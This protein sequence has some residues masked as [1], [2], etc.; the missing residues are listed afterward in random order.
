MDYQ[1]NPNKPK[2]PKPDKQI[3]KV[4]T[5]EV[6]QKPKGIGRKFR[7]VFLGGDLKNAARY[8]TGDVI[9][10]AFR[11]LLV[12]AITNGAKRFVYGESMY[13][14]RQTEYRPRVSYN[15]P[16][17]RGM[18]RDPRDRA[19]LPDQPHSYR[20]QRQERDDIILARRED[21]ELVVERLIDI[22]NQYDV[23]SLADLYDLLGQQ[24]SHV[25]NKW[26][27]TYLNNVEIR[28][29]RDGYLI[30]LPDLEPI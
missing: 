4:V 14:R 3:E 24:S 16:I 9:L 18:P 22:V 26:G 25:D 30:N 17:Y 11:D 13:R 28:Q 8:V 20:Q 23:A 10:P 12:D 29:V 2:E 15:N 19:I 21:A 5:G 1:G 27:W 7:D 6:I